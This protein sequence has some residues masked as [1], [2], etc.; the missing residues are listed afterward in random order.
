MADADAYGVRP[1][2]QQLSRAALPMQAGRDSKTYRLIGDGSPT[3]QHSAGRRNATVVEPGGTGELEAPRTGEDLFL[4]V[5][6]GAGQLRNGAATA[7][8]Q[9]DVLLARP[10]TAPHTLVAG[11]SALSYLSFYLPAFLL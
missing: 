5:T 8:G 3:V 10:D 2:Y 11:D 6:D 9:Y 4:Y 7:V 1:H